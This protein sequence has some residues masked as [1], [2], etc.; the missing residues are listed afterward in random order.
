[1]FWTVIQNLWNYSQQNKSNW[2][3]PDVWV[4]HLSQEHKLFVKLHDRHLSQIMKVE[5]LMSM[6]IIMPEWFHKFMFSDIVTN[7]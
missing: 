4:S 6:R 2:L 7:H 3:N 5:S 1:M